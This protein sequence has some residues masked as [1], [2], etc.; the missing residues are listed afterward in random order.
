MAAGVRSGIVEFHQRGALQRIIVAAQFKIEGQAEGVPR[1]VLVER[2]AFQGDGEV[3]DSGVCG[4][5]GG[6][7]VAEVG[8]GVARDDGAVV[9]VVEEP[10]AVGADGCA[11]LVAK[12]VDVPVGKVVAHADVEGVAAHEAAVVGVAAEGDGGVIIPAVFAHD[13]S[14]D[15]DVGDDD[16]VGVAV[17]DA[18]TVAARYAAEKVGTKDIISGKHGRNSA[19]T[20]GAL[21]V[22]HYAADIVDFH[23]RPIAADDDVAADGAVADGAPVVL[24]HDAA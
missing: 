22:A 9:A 12:S 10:E 23:Y 4:S 7:A 8:G 1:A 15:V 13:G 6:A 5:V 11:G 3:A 20:D 21:V 14:D 19:A 2:A 16:S 24:A 18:A 17:G